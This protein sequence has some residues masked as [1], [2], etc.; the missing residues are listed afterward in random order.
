VGVRVLEVSNYRSLR[1]L[2][3]DLASPTVIVGPNGSG[4]T[5]LYRALWLLSA[6]NRG[7]LSAELVAEGG[8]PS[9]VWAGPRKKGVVRV[10]LSIELDDFAYALSFGPAGPSSPFVL[11]AEVKEESVVV[12]DG[13]RRLRLAERDHARAMVRD[14]EGN[15][16]TLSAAAWTGESLLSQLRD[17][18]RFPVLAAL[19]AELSQW[20]FY[21][22]FRTDLDAPARQPH[23]VT[24]TPVLADDG[25]DLGPA[26]MTIEEIG[27][28]QALHRHVR[29]ALGAE[30]RIEP[31]AAQRARVALVVPGVQRPMEAQELS[32]GSLRFLCLATALLSPRPPPLLVLNEPETSLHPEVLPALARLIHEAARTTQVVLTTHAGALAAEVSR[33]SGIEPIVLE[34]REGETVVAGPSSGGRPDV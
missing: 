1:R 15:R 13:G 16:V 26:I 21:H 17:P 30:L 20:R 19:Q 22:S 5:N 3:V 31:D 18:T 4:K 29:E 14:G 8:V 27:D 11:D 25:R 32:D 24:L 23:P 6:A 7:R 34:K 12:V 2:R 9:V 33:H 10:E 28:G